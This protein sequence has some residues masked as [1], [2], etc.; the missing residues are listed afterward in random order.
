MWVH[1]AGKKV[2]PDHRQRKKRIVRGPKIQALHTSASV[3]KT[4]KGFKK[5][6]RIHHKKQGRR[7]EDGLD[8]SGGMLETGGGLLKKAEAQ[9]FWYA[10]S[11]EK[12]RGKGEVTQ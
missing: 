6:K 8:R 11:T 1:G 5:K 9:V 10:I 4:V 2:C 12:T 3:T 7:L